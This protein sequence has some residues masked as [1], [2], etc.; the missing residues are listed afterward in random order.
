MVITEKSEDIPEWRVFTPEE[1]NSKSRTGK[2]NSLANNS[3]ATLRLLLD[4]VDDGKPNRV[5]SI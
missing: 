5:Y 2:P 3:L 1:K 4:D